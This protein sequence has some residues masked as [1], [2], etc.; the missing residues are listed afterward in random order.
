VADEAAMAGAVAMEDV[1]VMADVFSAKAALVVPGARMALN[2]PSC[3]VDDGRAY[4]IC[5]TLY[6]VFYK[7]DADVADDGVVPGH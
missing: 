2:I 5:D 4:N 1:A 3:N 7:Y 6:L